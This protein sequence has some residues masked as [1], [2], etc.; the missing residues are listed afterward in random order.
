MKNSTGLM[1]ATLCAASALAVGGP[2][3]AQA[4]ASPSAPAPVTAPSAAAPAAPSAPAAAPAPLT[5]APPAA[6][7]SA[8]AGSAAAAKRA[9]HADAGEPRATGVAPRAPASDRVDLDATTVT[10]N[11]ESP[12]VMYIVPWKKS[13]IGD[14]AG[15][16]MNSLLDE[17]LAPVDRDVFRREVKYYDALHADAPQNGAAPPGAASRPAD[18][19][20]QVEK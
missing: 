20:P 12:K 18:P 19:S 5:P 16:P 17:V 6:A 14:L 7:D 13:D 15:K 3:A 2:A 1:F 4:V 10:G 8:A 11:Q 9:A